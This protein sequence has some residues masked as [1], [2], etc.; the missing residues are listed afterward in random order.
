LQ[1]EREKAVNDIKKS[2]LRLS[3]EIKMNHNTLLNLNSEIKEMKSRKTHI[4]I[5]LKD[6]YLKFFK[7]KDEK[8]F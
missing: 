4:Q 3:D 1:D 2:L 6:L 8:Q 5:Q 7:E